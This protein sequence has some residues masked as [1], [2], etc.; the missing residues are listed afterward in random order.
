MA[1]GW[2][3]FVG[4]ALVVFASCGSPA[5]IYP[6][7][8]FDPVRKCLEPYTSLATIDGTQPGGLCGVVCLL[9]PPSAGAERSVYVSTECEPYPPLYDSSGTSPDCAGALLAFANGPSCAPVDAG[10][11]PDAAVPDSGVDGGP[12]PDAG[13]TD[14]RPDAADA[15]PE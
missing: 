7:R 1:P 8:R 5:Y 4:V 10:S 15:A 6:A 13:I 3:R 12:P 11:T 2:P 9:A 14:A